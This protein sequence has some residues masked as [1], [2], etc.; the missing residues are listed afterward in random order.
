MVDEYYT[1]EA[2]QAPASNTEILLQQ[3]VSEQA[4]TRRCIN[5]VANAI[6]KN[7]EERERTCKLVR[8]LIWLHLGTI[9][10]AA[11][12]ALSM[13]AAPKI[14]PQKPSRC[15]VLPPPD[16]IRAYR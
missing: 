14:L 7:T 12:F 10:A 8:F 9:I 5:A 4:S 3:L 16:K 6:Q 1:P 11:V 15:L 2:E 13:L